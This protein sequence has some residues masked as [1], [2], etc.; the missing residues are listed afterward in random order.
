[1]PAAAELPQKDV[2]G[3]DVEAFVSMAVL[4]INAGNYEDAIKASNKA[5]TLD[6]DSSEALKIKGDAYLLKEE[7]DNAISLYDE[8]LKHSDDLQLQLNRDYAFEQLKME[9][10][11][12]KAMEKLKARK[13][14][15]KNQF[16]LDN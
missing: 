8:A 15:R 12:I 16:A 10:S 1:M 2:A 5:L 14:G 11:Q 3:Y 9:I 7:Y 13:Q 4:A 6:P